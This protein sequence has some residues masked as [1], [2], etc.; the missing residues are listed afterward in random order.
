M[1]ASGPLSGHGPVGSQGEVRPVA[2][3]PCTTRLAFLNLLLL[4]QQSCCLLE[5]RGGA[6][7]NVSCLFDSVR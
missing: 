7:P 2:A 4:A 1:H 3:P 6:F 5:L